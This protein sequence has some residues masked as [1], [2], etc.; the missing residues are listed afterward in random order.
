M[1]VGL[2]SGLLGLAGAAIVEA[3]DFAA[4]MRKAN[5]W[6]W[7]RAAEAGPVLTALI[8][9]LGAAGLLV[10][11]VGADGQVKSPIA[12]ASLG[13]ATPYVVEKLIQLGSSFFSSAGGPEID[14]IGKKSSGSS[15]FGSKNS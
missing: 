9:R 11:I 1:M 10:G 7:R 5:N 6:P 14:E 15:D 2:Q 13:M 12:L 8:L 4:H 3:L